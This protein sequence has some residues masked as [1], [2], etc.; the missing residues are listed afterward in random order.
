MML[1]NKTFTLNNQ[2]WAIHAPGFVKATVKIKIYYYPTDFVKLQHS[3]I[4]LN[5]CNT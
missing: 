5:D 3:K 2:S 1:Q 4:L